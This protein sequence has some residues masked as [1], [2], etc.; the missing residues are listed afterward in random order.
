MMILVKDGITAIDLQLAI[1]DEIISMTP[2]NDRLLI[3]TIMGRRFIIANDLYTIV[4]I[5]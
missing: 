1:G 4:E 2:W 5:R 3:V